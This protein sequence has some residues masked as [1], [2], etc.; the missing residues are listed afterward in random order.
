LRE[1]SQLLYKEVQLLYKEYHPS[2]DL[3]LLLVEEPLPL[4]EVPRKLEEVASTLDLL[5]AA[6]SIQR[7]LVQWPLIQKG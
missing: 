4:E 2:E 6:G 1:E 5:R 7:V 3:Q